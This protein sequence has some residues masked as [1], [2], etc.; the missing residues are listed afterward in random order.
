MQVLSPEEVPFVKAFRSQ[1]NRYFYDVNTNQIIRVDEATYEIAP[2][3]SPKRREELIAE[4]SARFPRSHIQNIFD[5]I[6]SAQRE[7][8]LLQN[9]PSDLWRWSEEEILRSLN[10]EVAHM[11]LCLTE[12]C[13]LRCDYCL[14]SGK[15][16]HSR[17][18][19][20]R[21]MSE[22]VVNLALDFFLEHSRG[23]D[24]I[25]FGFYGGEPLLEWDLIVHAVNRWKQISGSKETQFNI[26]TNGL[27][28]RGKKAKFLA[29]HMVQ[30]LVS[31]DG[32]KKLHDRYRKDANGHGSFDR[33]IS[34]LQEIEKLYPEYYRKKIRFNVILA[35]P[36]D[37]FSLSFFFEDNDVAV[38]VPFRISGVDSSEN[39]FLS[40]FHEQ[41]ISRHEFDLFRKKYI[42]IMVNKEQP[43]HLLRQ[44]FEGGM[45]EIHNR[46]CNEGSSTYFPLNGICIPGVTK[47]FVD[48]YGNLH[49]CEKLNPV[50]PIG[51]VRDGFNTEKI[52]KLV[53]TYHQASLKD[54]TQCWAARFCRLCWTSVVGNDFDMNLRKR[55][56]QGV[57]S[58]L[59]Y[60]LQLYCEILEQ[61]EHAFESL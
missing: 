17:G 9:R 58:N 32:P 55:K 24:K 28:L 51:N 31:L 21:R 27:L 52:L 8:L 3:Y 39:T 11:S 19:S 60:D 26:T 30:T 15:Y 61:N 5:S 44:M 2:R 25:S 33:A 45:R 37:L 10:T 43:S 57:R 36:Y 41:D 4:F 46:V 34:N 12:N 16:T 38:D 56:C 53:K 23:I 49:I 50:V 54:C 47:T 22:N 20:T 29:E 18:H 6:E 13:N 48:V 35:P 7:G 42:E 59:V 1:N 40:Q 14:Y